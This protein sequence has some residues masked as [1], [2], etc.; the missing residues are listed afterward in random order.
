[1]F[2]DLPDYSKEL[3]RV[4]KENAKEAQKYRKKSSYVDSLTYFK[5]K[6][7]HKAEWDYKREDNWERDIKV[8]YLE[9]S[10]KFIYNGEV[11]TAEDF[12]N[13][14]YDYVGKAMG[15]SNTLLYVGGGYVHCGPNVKVLI[16]PYNCDDENDHRSIKRGIDMYKN[17]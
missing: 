8:P 14:H 1:M 11:T 6:E 7:N 10:G 9:T 4:L 13:I 15:F 17:K 16:G 5:N 2:D 3:N 12:G